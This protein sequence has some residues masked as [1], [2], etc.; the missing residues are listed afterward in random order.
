VL[1]VR[2]FASALCHLAFT[3]VIVICIAKIE[4]LMRQMRGGGGSWNLPEV[5]KARQHNALK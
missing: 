2:V 3:A 1:S 4:G 5:K